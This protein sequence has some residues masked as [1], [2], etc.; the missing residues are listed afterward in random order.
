MKKKN[1][2]MLVLD[3]IT[4]ENVLANEGKKC[5]MPFIYSLM[6]NGINVKKVY[7]EAPYT[8]APDFPSDQ[9]SVT[10]RSR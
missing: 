2:I 1:V 8:D 6:Q 10:H 4:Y 7:S 5:P 9:P 3:S